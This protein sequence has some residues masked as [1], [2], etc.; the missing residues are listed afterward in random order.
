VL[1]PVK[2]PV[3]VEVPVVGTL[4]STGTFTDFGSTAVPND[5]NFS[6]FRYSVPAVP[7]H[8]GTG[9]R[10]L[11]LIPAF[12]IIISYRNDTILLQIPSTRGSFHAKNPTLSR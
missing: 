5:E 2:V 8:F 4:T 3:P 7:V 6:L 10:R 9:Y 11:M 1:V 12:M